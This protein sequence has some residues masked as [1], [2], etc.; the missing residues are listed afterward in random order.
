METKIDIKNE[1]SGMKYP[2]GTF[3]DRCEIEPELEPIDVLMLTLDAASFLER[4]LLSVYREIPVRRLLVCDGGSKDGTI[5]ILKKYPR[6]QLFIRPDIRTTG[7]ATEF[8]LSKIETEWFI[9]I[10][11][12]I[13]LAPGWYDE[14][15]KYKAEYDML[16]NSRRLM[17]YYFYREDP[18]KLDINARAYDFCYLGHKESV[19]NF[20][21]DDDYIWGMND[22]YFRQIIEKFGYKYGKVPSTY[23]LHYVTEK[24]LRKSDQEKS[25]HRV[26]FKEPEWVIVDKA[27]YEHM[28]QKFIKGLVKYID[29]EYT[30]VKDDPSLDEM[31]IKLLSRDWVKKNGPAW[32]RRYDRAT[33]LETRFRRKLIAVLIAAYSLLRKKV[34]IPSRLRKS[35]L[36]RKILNLRR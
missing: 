23:H 33:S 31:M 3:I 30:L 28:L 2:I 34:K 4:C 14:M 27:K 29:P 21:C 12:D 22:I 13:E 1:V 9:F 20:K 11:A 16:E 17:A 18:G 19:K 10:D 25:F 15:C 8:L 24:I 32:L 36:L 7:K 26:V 5:E 35:S 6:V